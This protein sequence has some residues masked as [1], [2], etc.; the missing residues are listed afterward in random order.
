MQINF[1]GDNFEITPQLK[2]LTLKK[3]DRLTRH[4][5]RITSI[6]VIFSVQKLTQRAESI[7]NLPGDQIHASA[8]SDDLYR[9]IDLLVKKLDSQVRKYK[10]KREE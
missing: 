3:F 6:Q 8:E 2:E 10:E 1:T 5:D 9:S 7:I 4:F